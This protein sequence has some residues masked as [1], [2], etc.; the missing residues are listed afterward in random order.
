MSGFVVPGKCFP[1]DSFFFFLY[2][3]AAL[4]GKFSARETNE[5]ELHRCML[6]HNWSHYNLSL[7]RTIRRIPEAERIRPVV[8]D[9]EW[10]VAI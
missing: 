4:A 2:W 8:A 5:T 6:C 10:L 9:N 3:S 7:T 1:L